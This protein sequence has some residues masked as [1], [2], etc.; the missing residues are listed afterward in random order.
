[1]AKHS[2]KYSKNDNND[3]QFKRIRID[4]L[5]TLAPLT[6]NQSIVY[7]KFRLNKNLVL[8]GLAG[9]GKTFISMYLALEQVLDPSNDYRE[10]LIVRS[11]VPTRDMGFMPGDEKDK[12]SKYEA[13]YH[14]VCEELFSYKDAYEALKLQNT[15][16]FI[17]TSFIRGATFNN[18]IVIVDECSNLTFHELDSII[19]RIGKNSKIVFCGDYRQTDLT[20]DRDKKGLHKFIEITKTMQEFEYVEFEVGDIVRSDF[21]KS[22]IIAKDKI[23]KNG[24]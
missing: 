7:S 21:V 11:T 17:S 14:S 22:Y 15:V 1:M 20:L 19:T 23:E 9:T 2:K 6:N 3:T 8:H 18:A 4:D 13:P 12:I 16:S 24:L 10:I 5:P